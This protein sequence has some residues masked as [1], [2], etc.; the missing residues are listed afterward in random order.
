MYAGA[1]GAGEAS[2]ATSVVAT[3]G[4]PRGLVAE[5]IL[6]ASTSQ[7]RDSRHLQA[8][9]TPEAA[10]AQP[11]QTAAAGGCLC[12][13]GASGEKLL[14]PPYCPAAAFRMQCVQAISQGSMCQWVSGAP[15]V[16]AGTVV[17]ITPASV[18]LL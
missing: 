18:E 14:W 8:A 5:G 4:S 17:L 9:A 12:G 1:L 11:G 2:P 13:R 10:A 16:H 7:P 6:V 3:P 15:A